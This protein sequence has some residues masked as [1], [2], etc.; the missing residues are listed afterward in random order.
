LR[1][2]DS[3]TH[4]FP[5]KIA[6]RAMSSLEHGAHIKAKLDG[7]V[8]SLLKSMDA[9]GI[10]R[11]VICSIA[12][13]PEQFAPIMKWSQEIASERIIPLASIHPADPEAAQK[14]KLVHDAGLKG[15]KLHPYYQ[16]FDLD[17]PRALPIYEEIQRY[18]LVLVS[19]TGFDMAFPF[20]R[21]ADA[22]RIA[23][24]MRQFPR[25]KMIT[26]HLGAWKDWELVRELLLGKPIYMEISFS[27][28]FMER[29]IARE[30]LT[31]HPAE[32]L[33]FGTDSPWADQTAAVE[34]LKSFDLP[35]DRLERIFYGNAAG[36]FG[37]DK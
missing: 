19:H 6:E 27:L 26:T 32:Y 12:T 10:E 22:P 4:A 14:V 9:A 36:L 25:L 31:K 1:I 2:I 35:V 3:H 29:D 5:D 21:R 30:L 24:V 20:V 33:I 11:S 28:D 34:A 13:K 8:A 17:E 15:I 37:L 18:G 7:R 23:A 16:E